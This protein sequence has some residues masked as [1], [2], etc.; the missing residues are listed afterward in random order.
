MRVAMFFAER[1]QQGN[2]IAIRK[3][4]NGQQVDDEPLSEQELEDF[5]AGEYDK[6]SYEALLT[7]A[8]KKMIRVL[9]DLIE[10][11][12]NKNIILLTDLPDEAREKLGNRREVRKRMHENGAELTVDDI[13]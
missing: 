6:T 9:D 13:L 4:S 12:V 7:A 10:I 11:L 8:D 5:L 2:I 1:D 3:D